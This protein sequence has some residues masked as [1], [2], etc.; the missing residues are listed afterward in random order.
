MKILHLFEVYPT[1]S[2]YAFSLDCWLEYIDEDTE[3]LVQERTHIQADFEFTSDVKKHFH[4]SIDPFIVQKG[5][6]E[7]DCS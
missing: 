7:D 2:P 6:E 3:Q 5:N 1:D 4:Q